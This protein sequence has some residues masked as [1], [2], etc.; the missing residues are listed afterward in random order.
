MK[1][2]PITKPFLGKEEIRSVKLPL[3][4]GWLVQGSLVKTF[5]EKFSGFTNSP[6]SIATT[7]CNTALHV[8]VVAMCLNKEDEVIVPSFTWITTPNVI[9]YMGAKP[10]FC[11]IDLSTFNIDVNL[12][13][14][15]ITSRT[16]GIIPVHLFGLCADMN[17]ILEL[18]K[19]H[20]LWVI[21]DAACALGSYYHGK[22]AGNFGAMGCFSFHPRKLITTGE[23]GMVT[24]SNVDLDKLCRVLRD[25]GADGTDFTHLGFNYRMTDIQGSLGSSQMDK[26][27]IIL[28]NRVQKANFYN[29]ALKEIEWLKLPSVPDEYVHSYQSYV[30]LFRPEDPSMEN[31]NSLNDKRNKLMERLKEKGISTRSG[32]ISPSIQQFYKN[33]YKYQPEDFPNSYIADRLSITLP[34]YAQMTEK[35]Q[36]RVIRGLKKWNMKK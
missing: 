1:N 24:T 19:K 12:I 6:F 25:H 35:D 3:K 9:E 16:V 36:N 33:K 4:S 8:A 31:V 13:E 32:T 10:V 14:S 22:H 11:D 5:E 28:S 15:L 20:N 18:A 27:N 21:E 30:C 23:G 17:P 34:L 26:A 7:S 29:E 2:I